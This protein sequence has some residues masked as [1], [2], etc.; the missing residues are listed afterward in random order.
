MQAV[1]ESPI[2][3][4]LPVQPLAMSKITVALDLRETD[5][6]IL[7]Y[8][9]FFVQ[10]ISVAKVDFINVLR[11]IDLFEA[12]ETKGII[13]DYNVTKDFTKKMGAKVW[14][15]VDFPEK[16]PLDFKILEGNPMEE[17]LKEI[18]DQNIDLVVMGFHT[19]Y[20]YHGILPQALAR[21]I[22]TNFL[23]IPDGS[24]PQL[25]RVLVPIDFSP[26]SIVALQTVAALQKNYGE[27]L[28]IIC[29]NV[30]QL[31]NLHFFNA[32]ETAEKLKNIIEGDRKSAFEAYVKDFFKGNRDKIS[33]E[34][35]VQEAPGIGHYIT[36]FADQNDI[37]LIVI[38][39][40]GHSGIDRILLGSVAEQV[41][42][43]PKS[44]P[45]WVVK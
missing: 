21:E 33:I 10:K 38:G 14:E 28:E 32:D 15:N 12:K 6:S 20:A 3:H 35:M 39:A 5:K 23:L 11:P 34:L 22:K 13:G 19:G 9:N 26:Y 1:N 45:I 17:L 42:A 37:D 2:I 30:Y 8:L 43:Y 36:D 18:D 24:R 27:E 7:Q 41:L 4:S 44:K 25:K 40:K 29:L 31:P 16:I